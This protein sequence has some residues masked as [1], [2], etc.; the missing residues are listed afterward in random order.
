MKIPDVLGYLIE[1]AVDALVAAGFKPV[2]LESYGKKVIEAGTARVIRQR[3]ISNEEIE[4]IIS[5]F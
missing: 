4:L 1:D 3:A 2:I 5:L